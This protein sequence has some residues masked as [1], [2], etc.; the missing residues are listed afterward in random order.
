[1]N[2][3]IQLLRL[4]AEVFNKSQESTA[5][6]PKLVTKLQKFYKDVNILLRKMEK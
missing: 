6:H 4:I 1:M 3:D 5:G 2:C